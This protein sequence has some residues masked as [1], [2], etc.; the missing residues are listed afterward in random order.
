VVVIG[1][2]AGWLT[3]KLMSGAGYGLPGDLVLGIIGAY[4]GGWALGMAGISA[5]GF[6]GRIVSATI[7]AVLFVFLIRLIKRA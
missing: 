7:G 3:G 6:I 2:V 1:V 4:V 5:G